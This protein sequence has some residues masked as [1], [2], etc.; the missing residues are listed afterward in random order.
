MLNRTAIL[1][2]LVVALFAVQVQVPAHAAPPRDKHTGASKL[3]TDLRV[4]F[5]Q[6]QAGTAPAFAPRQQGSLPT[7]SNANPFLRVSD[8]KVLIDISL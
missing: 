3:G 4:L 6:H 7:P 1:L 8:D 2:A 5:E